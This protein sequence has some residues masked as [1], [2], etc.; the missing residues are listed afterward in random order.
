[1][2]ETTGPHGVGLSWANR[3]TSVGPID[4][5]NRSKI[6]NKG[7]D[8]SGELCIYGRH[9]FMGYLN[10]REKTEETFDADGWL[11]TG[12]IGKI[13]SDGY[14]YIT[15]RL[16][17]LIITAGGENVAPIPIEDRVKS[18]LSDIVSNC[19][20]V[21]DKKK[22]LVM[23]V[24][25][26]SKVNPDTQVPLDELTHGCIEALKAIGS[27]STRVSEI[28]DNKDSAVYKKIDAGRGNSV[29]LRLVNLFIFRF[30]NFLIFFL[31]LGIKSAN[32]Y[33]TSRAAKVQKF[34]I[35]PKDFSLA[36]G[37][38]GPTLKLRRQIVLKMYPDVIEGLYTEKDSSE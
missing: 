13:D 4:Q 28:V 36:N 9:V 17:E 30:F 11:H 29:C 1:M 24:T 22:Y 31:K 10:S 7:E 27:N 18:E 8:D 15:G 19:M 16:K 32:L 2:S 35:L 6:V 3:V 23:L 33:S 5:F 14:L 34:A 21:G 12:D 38:L 25:L 37:E 26:K 20:L